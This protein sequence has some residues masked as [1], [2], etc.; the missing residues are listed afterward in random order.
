MNPIRLALCQIR[1]SRDCAGNIERAF[2]MISTAAA[3]GRDLVIL[4][5]MFYHPYE[6]AEIKKLGD[7]SG[8]LPRFQ[9]AA[10]NDGVFIC[11]GS[12][13][14]KSPPGLTNTAFLIDPSGTVIL[15]YS[16]THLFEM[17]HEKVNVQESAVFSAGNDFPV[18]KS[19]LGTIGMLIC[20]DIRFPEAALNLALAGA[21]LLI[22]PAN[23]NQVTGPAHWQVML[24]A[25]A[26]ENQ[27]FLAAVSQ[28]LNPDASYAAYGHSMVVSPW[29]DIMAEAGDDEEIVFA[30]LDPRMI[31]AIRKKLPLLRNRRSDLFGK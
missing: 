3:K 5:E 20:Y 16:K 30:D 21:E 22:V 1:P 8:L 23:F 27:V 10:R 19:R 13:A 9:A 2:D 26:M 31:E 18:S 6:L 28:A 11:T 29:G 17:Y 14:I 4:P 24:R 25:R 15:T 12:L 7:M